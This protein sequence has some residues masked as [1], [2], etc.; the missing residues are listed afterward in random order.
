MRNWKYLIWIVAG[1]TVLGFGL[2]Y[3]VRSFRLGQIDYAIG[4]MRTLTSNEEDFATTHPARG[5][6]CKLADITNDKVVASGE[7]M[8]GYTFEVSDCHSQTR[9]G[10]HTTFHLAARPKS[11]KLPMYCTDET[12]SLKADY[13]D[14]VS[15]CVKS[16]EPL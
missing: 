9:N 1:L 13:T 15:D 4:R 12:F 2:T 14:S 5:Y 3:L 10:P 7:I 8:N 16:G 11:N 6:S